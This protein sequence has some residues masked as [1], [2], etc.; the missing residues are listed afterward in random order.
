MQQQQAKTNSPI[1][2]N[3]YKLIEFSCVYDMQSRKDRFES[4]KNGFQ[5]YF[6]TGSDEYQ[7]KS[8]HYTKKAIVKI[9]GIV[10]IYFFY[11]TFY[12]CYQINEVKYYL[13]SIFTWS[14]FY[15]QIE[16]RLML[17]NHF[18]TNDLLKMN[19]FNFRSDLNDIIAINNKNKLIPSKLDVTANTVN[20]QL[21]KSEETFE[22]SENID[23]ESKGLKK[24]TISVHIQDRFAKSIIEIIQPYFDQEDRSA[25]ESLLIFNISPNR[26]LNFQGHQNQLVSIFLVLY[27]NQCYAGEFSKRYISKWLA[28]HF[29]CRGVK[30]VKE[31]NAN[32]AEMIMT[33]SVHRTKK[34][35]IVFKIV[36]NEGYIFKSILRYK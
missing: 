12:Y 32:T 30:G 18:F 2:K 3:L 20:P 14:F 27:D 21:N 10:L 29:A 13:I 7:F 34:P 17:A 25:L 31:V 15:W 28:V 24:D 19:L 26:R 5:S 9:I 16:L 1:N 4:F 35:L 11:R 8:L 6:D 22:T 23:G 36:N 33:E